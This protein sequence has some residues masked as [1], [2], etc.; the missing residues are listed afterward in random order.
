MGRVVL[1]GACLLAGWS[2]SLAGRGGGSPPAKTYI[3]LPNGQAVP[4]Q[5]RPPQE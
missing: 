5:T 1:L 2:S 3:I 4:A